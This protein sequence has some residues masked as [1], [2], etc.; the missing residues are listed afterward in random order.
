MKES[1]FLATT[2]SLALCLMMLAACSTSEE[3]PAVEALLE[4]PRP[5]SPPE[6][7][8]RSRLLI[9]PAGSEQLETDRPLE[10]VERAAPAA[11]GAAADPDS[12]TPSTPAPPAP[13]P[14]PSPAATIEAEVPPAAPPKPEQEAAAAPRGEPQEERSEAESTPSVDE[15][16][17]PAP[18]EVAA[19]GVA[20]DEEAAAE[21][22]EEEV[23]ATAPEVAGDE[24]EGSERVI[25]LERLEPEAPSQQAALP[26]I[27]TPES[28][29]LQFAAGEVELTDEMRD[30]LMEIAQQL[31]EHEDERVQLLAYASGFEED[32]SRARR[33]S[34]ARALAVRAF[35]L[36]QGVRSTRMDV[37]ALARSEGN[38][39]PDRVDVVPQE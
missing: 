13:P 22:P 10:L 8:P 27:T 29:R 39:P 2:S 24:E 21:P 3:P 26:Q 34:L 31:R 32:I 28:L 33:L 11:T 12:S 25:E 16:V 5:L 37:R 20:A 35:L 15:E 7:P 23:S 6:Q 36:D 30:R 18:E 9:T 17:V 19:E 38:A 1:A 14:R 4:D